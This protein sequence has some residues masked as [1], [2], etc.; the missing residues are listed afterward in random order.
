MTTF[1]IA[2]A[3]VGGA[4]LLKQMGFAVGDSTTIYNNAPPTG[5]G[6][7]PVSDPDPNS[8]LNWK[9][10]DDAVNALSAAAKELDNTIGD[11]SDTEP[12]WLIEADYPDALF[13]RQM[14]LPASRIPLS[15]LTGIDFALAGVFLGIDPRV[16][17]L[18]KGGA[19]GCPITKTEAA[20]K[21]V[22]DQFEKEASAAGGVGGILNIVAD[23]FGV[24]TKQFDKEYG[25][26]R[27]ATE[28]RKA[29]F[30]LSSL[31]GARV[32]NLKLAF[33]HETPLQRPMYQ[34]G[35]V[36]SKDANFPPFV[37]LRRRPDGSVDF[38][39]GT[40]LSEVGSNDK[41]R[42]N[43]YVLLAKDGQTRL[44]SRPGTGIFFGE[45]KTGRLTVHGMAPT[46]AVYPNWGPYFR[47]GLFQM[48][49][50]SNSPS[51]GTIDKT[52]G[53]KDIGEFSLPWNTPLLSCKLPPRVRHYARARLYR[54]LDYLATLIYPTELPGGSYDPAS[55]LAA[56]RP[57]PAPLATS[58]QLFWYRLADGT[59]IHGSIFPPHPADSA[60]KAPAYPYLGDAGN[61]AP[62]Q[63][64][65]IAI[66]GSST[67]APRVVSTGE[68]AKVQSVTS[69][70]PAAPA[71]PA[72][73]TT[74]VGV[75][76]ASP[77]LKPSATSGK[78]NS[79]V[80]TSL[81]GKE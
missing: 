49:K 33:S 16:P 19:G 23:I 24:D 57:Q 43:Q 51:P 52:S 71:R 25:L 61:S 78:L 32:S 58:P 60:D 9:T 37:E 13:L 29:K 41:A 15:S 6:I 2:L 38:S 59:K 4:F 65:A 17:A 1:E 56:T 34:T 75:F 66:V 68:P 20:L 70:A 54:T 67:S 62:S 45:D 36:K 73:Q 11:V 21:K 5:G 77:I 12:D 40:W 50:L 74:S 26:G 35:D 7:L 46:G 48:E 76:K 28:I 44:F 8:P 42:Y 10:V 39:Q 27:A 30:D 22:N 14:W 53:Y 79:A 72:T 64:T 69:A 81:K 47:A 31:Q 63:T 80:L 55:I 3:I 18:P